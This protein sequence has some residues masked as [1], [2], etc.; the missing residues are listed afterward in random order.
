MA[1]TAILNRRYMFLQGQCSSHKGLFPGSVLIRTASCCVELSGSSRQAA[2]ALTAGFLYRAG[3][4]TT[5]K[6]RESVRVSL[7]TTFSAMDTQSAIFVSTAKIFDFSTG[8]PSLCFRWF[9]GCARSWQVLLRGPS[10]DR[11]A[12]SCRHTGPDLTVKTRGER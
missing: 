2:H 11:I 9:S 1:E 3:A 7:R 6:F 4:Q 5:P 12:R 8:S 10:G